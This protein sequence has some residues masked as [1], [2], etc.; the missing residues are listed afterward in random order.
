MNFHVMQPGSSIATSLMP[1]EAVTKNVA[2]LS[3]TGREFKVDPIKLKTVRPFIMKEIVLSEEKEAVK[4]AKKPNHR[5]ELTRFLS[6]IV[7]GMIEEA[8]AEWHEAQDG[9]NEE[10]GEPPLPLIRLRVEFSSPDGFTFDCENPQRFSS[11]FIDTVANNTD[12]VQ[13]HRKKAGATRRTRTEML[14][15]STLESLTND[16][17]NVEK[18][19]REF[20]TAQTLTILPPSYFG[21]AVGEFVDKD[22]KSAIDNFV[23]QKLK[24]ENEFIADREDADNEDLAEGMEA[25]KSHLEKLFESERA[26]SSRGK[27]PRADEWDQDFQE[28]RGNDANAV[29]RS[30]VE[31]DDDS[32]DAPP[33]KPAARGRGKAST[34]AASGAARKTTTTKSTRGKKKAEESEEDED[35]VMV[36][37]DDDDAGLFVKP[38]PPARGK[39]TVAPKPAPATRSTP[40]RGTAVPATRQSQLNFSQAGTQSKTNGQKAHEISDDDISDDDEDEDAFEPISSTRT[41]RT[42]K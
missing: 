41:S 15:E 16:N 22:D 35:I 8:N 42:R 34:T 32:E 21:E 5:S 4:I 23:S 38:G 36:D 33:T 2:I 11:R 19:I 17:L 28:G 27:K 7:T 13:F 40:A 1:G 12:V 3:I 6:E 31:E 24:T 14:E 30:N 9:E 26:R 20:L 29:V 39:K 18:I 10:D 37:S 25:A